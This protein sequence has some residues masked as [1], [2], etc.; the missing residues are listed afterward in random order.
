MSATD[1]QDE[2]DDRFDDE[3]MEEKIEA[4]AHANRMRDYWDG[5]LPDEDED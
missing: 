2:R 5:I 1:E 4:R 3:V